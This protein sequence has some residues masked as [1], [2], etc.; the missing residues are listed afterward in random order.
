VITPLVEILVK[1]ELMDHK[2]SKE[3]S[4]ISNPH[5]DGNTSLLG[6]SRSELKEGPIGGLGNLRMFCSGR[7]SKYMIPG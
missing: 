7:V 4:M 3:G 2:L 5:P 6:G 1:A